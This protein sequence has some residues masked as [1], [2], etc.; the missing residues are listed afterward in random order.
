MYISNITD[1]IVVLICISPIN[2]N[3]YVLIGKGEYR[4]IP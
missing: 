2:L 4:P 1:K 3:L